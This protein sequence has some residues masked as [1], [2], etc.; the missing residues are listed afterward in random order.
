MFH[1]HLKQK[2]LF[3]KSG[4][5]QTVEL[6]SPDGSAI[7]HLLLAGVT[8]GAEWGLMH[9]NSLEIADKLYVTGNIFQDEKLLN[10]LPALPKSC[11]ESS[12]IIVEKRELYE[13][14]NIFPPSII[15]YVAKLLQAEND[16]NVNQYLTDLP[17]DHRLDEIHKIMH[18]DLHRH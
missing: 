4:G 16:E 13:R 5:R 18:K 2:E 8:M 1:L 14:K 15:E 7:V 3:E 10:K 12:R 6:R 17:E 11:I 9:S